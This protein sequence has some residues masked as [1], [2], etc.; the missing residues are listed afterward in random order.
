MTTKNNV[1]PYCG[2][3][4]IDP[5]SPYCPKCLKIVNESRVNGS[6][7]QI[8]VSNVRDY[9]GSGVDRNLI[10]SAKAKLF[11]NDES[12]I[13]VFAGNDPGLGLLTQYLIIMNN[14]VIF[15]KRGVLSESNTSFNFEDIGSVENY[16]SLLKNGVAV[17][18]KGAKE[19]FYDL[20]G[21]ELPMAISI[22]RDHIQRCKN[23]NMQPVISNSIPDQI[24]KLAEL[25][26]SGILTEQEFLNKKTELLKRM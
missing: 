23:Q 13:A 15:W 26:D 10:N 2:A 5:Y 21:S 9:Y 4:I 24:K 20:N 16:S 7:S 3:T 22:I 14:R 11:Q 1:C 6:L 19:I 18:I 8:D 25:R 17:N 12:L